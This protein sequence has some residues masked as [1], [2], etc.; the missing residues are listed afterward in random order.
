MLQVLWMQQV[1]VRVK[2]SAVDVA[3]VADTVDVVHAVDAV[4]EW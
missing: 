2:G 1:L 3:D 4:Y